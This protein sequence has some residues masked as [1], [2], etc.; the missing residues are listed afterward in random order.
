MFIDAIRVKDK[1]IV[2]ER[3]DKGREIKYYPAPWYFYHECDSG[4]YKSIYG[5]KL[6]RVTFTNRKDFE[7]EKKK[8]LRVYESDIRPERKV[9]M[10][11][12]YKSEFPDIHYTLVDIEVDY[13]LDMGFAGPD[14]PYAPINAITFWHSWTRKYH[15]IAVPPS[16]WV[17]MRTLLH[18]QLQTMLFESDEITKEQ[19]ETLEKLLQR[20]NELGM[21]CGPEDIHGFITDAVN[22]SI[23]SGNKKTV[24][25]DWNY[26]ID[27]DLTKTSSMEI[28]SNEAELLRRTLHHFQDTDVISGWNSEFFDMPYLVMRTEMVLGKNEAHSWCFNDAFKPAYSTV[29]RYGKEQTIVKLSGRQHLDYIA[30]FKKFNFDSRESYA[31]AAIAD[32]ELDLPKLTYE[33]SLHSLYRDDFNFFIRYNIRDVEVLVGLDDK[34]KYISMANEL[35]HTN[36][37]QF[38]KVLGS[39]EIIDTGIINYAHNERGLKV[40]DKTPKPSN[41][42][43]GA[44]V[45]N[46]K[47]G[48]HEWVGSAD[49]NSLYPSTYRALNISPE[50]IVGQFIECKKAWVGVRGRSD[51]LFTM[52]LNENYDPASTKVTKSGKE[53]AEYFLENRF[54]ISAYGTVFNQ[55]KMGIIPGILKEWYELRLKYKAEMKSWAKKAFD[56]ETGKVIDKDAAAK[57]E[58]FDGKQHTYKI[59][60]NSLYGATVNEFCT[61]F[62]E[63]LGASTTGTGKQITTHMISK[64]AEVLTGEYAEVREVREWNEKLGKYEYNYYCEN[65]SIVYSDTDSVYYKM[66]NAKNKEEAIAEADRVGQIVNESFVPFMEEAFFCTEGYKDKIAAAREV[67]GDKAIFQ[68]KKK[69]VIHVVDD[70]GKPSDK[71]KAMGSDIKKS[72]TPKYIQ[73][74]LSDVIRKIL[75]E[76]YDYKKIEK[77]INDFRKEF[78]S[79]E[80]NDLI[81]IGKVVGCNKLEDYMNE[82]KQIEHAGKG[83]VKLPGNVRPVINHNIQLEMRGDKESP[84][85]NAGDKVR[86]FYLKKNEYNY[87]SIAIPSDASSFPPWFFD[88]FDVSLDMM[89]EKL[90]DDKIDLIF[91]SIG[92]EV[93]TEQ[94]ASFN[95]MFDF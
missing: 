83:R 10:N 31:L 44:M 79:I 21:E 13:N 72:D 49:I 15:T 70:E 78:R 66:I 74:F 34:F 93:P 85:I 51:E 76:G 86:L 60:L 71:L 81:K 24:H 27:T 38:S 65:E 58:F 69:Y 12:Y 25:F 82:Y 9:L 35:V 95:S 2:W 41:G 59:L 7:E 46:P 33:G 42:I 17:Q 52:T 32:E 40:P 80:G 54:S 92:W 77:F 61:F 39:V 48:L 6:K 94:S 75:V 43:E 26:F 89:E 29:E 23:E 50:T 37:V 36:T 67:V 90:I 55:N 11:N 88:S 22:R 84:V 30:L 57:V 53:W 3:T 28:V 63:S 20:A 91:K 47:I 73:K 19:Y 64:S 18:A 62:N 45:L 8:H 5:K 16:Q 87:K 68:V 14:N 4:H 56:K 1:V